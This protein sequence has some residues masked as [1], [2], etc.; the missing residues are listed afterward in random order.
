MV[1]KLLQVD[2]A[3]LRLPKSRNQGADP[4]KLQLQ[5]ARFGKGTSGMP[6]P[7]VT[8]DKNGEL[9]ILDGVTRATRVAKLLPGALL[10]VL[11]TA[12]EPNKEYSRSP[13]V[14]DVLP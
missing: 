5:I 11:V 13:R 6:P 3:M 12:E 8:R 4:V 14:G 7:W 9:R 2:P 1:P 10:T